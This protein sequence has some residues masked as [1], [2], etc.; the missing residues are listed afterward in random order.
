MTTDDMLERLRTVLAPWAREEDGRFAPPM[1]AP[2]TIGAIHPINN[3]MKA[4]FG[5]PQAA[6]IIIISDNVSGFAWVCPAVIV[7][8]RQGFTANDTLLVGDHSP[9]AL[10]G[11]EGDVDTEEGAMLLLVDEIDRIPISVL[12]LPFTRIMPEDVPAV[13]ID[14][15]A[16]KEWRGYFR[17]FEPTG[18]TPWAPDEDDPSDPLDGFIRS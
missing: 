10:N 8:S 18:A 4:K 15:G 6:M 3:E 7:N 9:F 2:L 5:L 13:P 17:S 11:K 12:G 1:E 16:G 14:G